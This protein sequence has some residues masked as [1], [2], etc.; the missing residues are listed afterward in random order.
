MKNIKCLFDRDVEG[1]ARGKEEDNQ[2]SLILGEIR[3]M[4]TCSWTYNSGRNPSLI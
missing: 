2:K 4:K 1:I 3:D